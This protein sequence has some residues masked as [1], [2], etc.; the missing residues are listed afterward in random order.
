MKKIALFLLFIVFVACDPIVEIDFKA[1][2]QTIQTVQIDYNDWVNNHDTTIL[3]APNKTITLFR[4]QAV[5]YVNTYE[6]KY[7]TFPFPHFLLRKDTVLSTKNFTLKTEW[8]LDNQNRMGT[9]T[10]EIDD[11][12]F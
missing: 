8:T 11:D 5:G 1:R 10:L 12:D 6:N 4:D 2:N 3:L 7:D 9:Y